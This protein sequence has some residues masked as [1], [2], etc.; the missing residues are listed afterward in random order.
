ML[1]S[2][3]VVTGSSEPRCTSGG[4]VHVIQKSL[5]GQQV[6]VGSTFQVITKIT[7]DHEVL[8]DMCGDDTVDIF[9]L[10]SPMGLVLATVGGKEHTREDW[11]LR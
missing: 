3:S 10:G 8:A 5:H 11:C 6:I 9:V 4:K 2:K 1:S 7:N